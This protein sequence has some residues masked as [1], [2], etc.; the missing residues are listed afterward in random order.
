MDSEHLG[1]AAV[2]GNDRLSGGVQPEVRPGL[3][4]IFDFR[5]RRD[6]RPQIIIHGEVKRWIERTH[7]LPQICAEEHGLLRDMGIALA[8]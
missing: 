5:A 1:P 4:D 7:L 6:A 3:R 2:I 8:Q